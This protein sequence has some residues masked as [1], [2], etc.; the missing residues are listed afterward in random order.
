M[1]ESQNSIVGIKV[2][3]TIFAWY[4]RIWI[5]IRTYLWL[6]DPDPQHWHILVSAFFIRKKLYPT[7]LI[8]CILFR[9]EFVVFISVSDPDP[10]FLA[11][12]RSSTYAF[13]SRVLKLMTKN[14][15]LGLQ[16]RRPSYRRSH[17]PS[18]EN[19]QQNMT[20]LNFFLFLLGIFCPPGSGSRFPI[21]I[22]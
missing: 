3:L 13:G 9:S 20:F 12:N 2:F 21:W 18:I 16:K 4:R 10:A 11:E 1:K 7:N 14:L 22:F 8:F 17:Q 6:T 5:R 19:I 15:S